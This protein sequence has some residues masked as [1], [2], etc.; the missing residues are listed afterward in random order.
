V[1]QDRPKR[2][3]TGYTLAILSGAV[4]AAAVAF[5]TFNVSHE[6]RKLGSARSDNVQWSLLQTQVEFLEFKQAV[7]TD[8]ADLPQLREEFDVFYSRVTTLN[9]ATVFENLRANATAR[10]SLD[11]VLAFMEQSVPL[12]D[13]SDADLIRR[14]P[15]LK[16]M[17][18]DILPTVRA[19]GNSGLDLFAQES[20]T[21]RQAVAR[22][23][24]QLAVAIVA[25]IGFLTLAILYLNFLNTRI[26]RR[27]GQLRQTANRMQTVMGTSLD[28]VVV[29]NSNGEILEFN[30]AA[31]LIFGQKEQEVLGKEIGSVIVPDHL[32]DAHDAG[33]HR[34]RMAGEKRVVGKGR[35]KL[36]AKHSDGH[37][38]P[39]ELAI[40]SATTEHGDVFIAFLRDITH[41]VASEAEIVAARDKALASE[42]MKTDFLT[43]M[44]HE[45]RTPLNGLLGNMNLMRDTALN[46]D[47]DRFVGHMETSGRLLMSHISDVL[48]ITRYDAGKLST[49]S[50]PVNISALLQ[51][52]I[53]NQGST[54]SKNEASLVWG[55]TGP[56]MDWVLSDHDRLQH[57]M[58]NLIGNAVK[59]TKRGHVSVTIENTGAPDAPELLIQ[60]IDTGPGM[61]DDLSARVFD[62][63]VTGNTAYDRDVGGTGLGLSIAKRFVHALGG[64]IGVKSD[65]GQ[66]STFWVN[67]PVSE[68]QEPEASQPDILPDQ[69]GQPLK[70]LLVEDNEINR[71]VARE[72]LQFEGHTV[73]EAHDGSQGLQI[74]NRDWFDLI[75]MDISMP[76]MDGRTATRRIRSENGVSAHTTIVALTANAMIEEQ[77][78]FIKDGMDRILTKPLSRDALRLLLRDTQNAK[79]PDDGVV[80]INHNHSAETR[81]ALGEETFVKLRSRF[82]SEVDELY[83][84]LVSDDTLD[85]LEVASRAHK[86][87]GSAS[88]FGADRLRDQLKDIE[89]GAKTGD[90]DAIEHR[91]AAMGPIWQ[92]TKSEFI[93]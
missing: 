81:D 66:G 11:T 77:N 87:A 46:P 68:A 92:R 62:D 32:R 4:A 86:V 79:D 27:E 41:R 44:S 25:L 10:D 8:P 28:G 52:I 30:P 45:I 14:L 19:L 9:K 40:Q 57:V 70:V 6:I 49:R 84:W 39:V 3:R 58:M 12:I 51:D 20:D 67:L 2:A 76:V 35:V 1:S 54:A 29:C 72:M 80:L 88:V 24:M 56:K 34:M 48:D 17:T 38:F 13:G 64:E 91:I 5:L 33:M 50:E 74:A 37:I 26:Y 22:T 90:S 82:I 15:E 7:E 73:V 18:S 65:V 47:Q 43:T 89:K 75:L 53:D 16:S 69:P 71:I 78:E 63:F 42:K 60:I 85:F 21:Q 61:T 83:A 59:F 23:M 36:E 55:W 93:S 31:E